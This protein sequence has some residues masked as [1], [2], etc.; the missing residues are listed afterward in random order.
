MQF[1]KQAFLRVFT[2]LKA[3]DQVL[4]WFDQLDLL[5]MPKQDWILCKLALAEGFT[6]AVN[7]AHQKL[8]S[9]VPIEIE[10]TLQPTELTIRIWDW[11]EPFDLDAY[12][13]NLDYISQKQEL[14]SGRGVA[15]LCKIAD[16]LSYTRTEDHRNCLLIVRNYAPAQVN[17]DY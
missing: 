11:G 8:T 15:I 4:D 9:E 13:A 16:H 1:P 14:G 3:L 2:D 17:H 12:I 7:H 6:N 5:P 10:L